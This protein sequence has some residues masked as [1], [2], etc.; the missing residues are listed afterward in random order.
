MASQGFN[1]TNF[2]VYTNAPESLAFNIDSNGLVTRPQQVVFSGT[3]N[4]ES[5]VTGDG[6]PAAPGAV[7][8]VTILTNVGSGFRPGNGAGMGCSFISPVSGIY[9]FSFFPIWNVTPTSGS[10][11][12]IVNIL[13]PSY[14]YLFQNLPTSEQYTNFFGSNNFISLGT[15]C[16]SR[17]NSGNTATFTVT[18]SGGSKTASI[19]T[20][21]VSGIL[22]A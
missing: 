6:T 21:Y 14:T 5:N 10:I 1:N 22:L 20:G 15:S 18:I 17:M 12:A 8:P 4:L 19:S 16:I 13:T 7:T 11:T 9:L 2:N 3:L